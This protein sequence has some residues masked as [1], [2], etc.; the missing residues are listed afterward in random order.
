MSQLIESI[1]Y[2]IGV[3]LLTHAIWMNL[4]DR[5]RG[6]AAAENPN[7]APPGPTPVSQ[8][9]PARVMPRTC[10]LCGSTATHLMVIEIGA[11]N[12][13][14]R[15]SLHTN[16]PVC[17]R[18]LA[19]LYQVKAWGVPIDESRYAESFEPAPVKGGR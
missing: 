3:V 1:C 12:D 2:G 14:T 5:R 7:P 11:A 10:R 8:I 9:K 17:L 4:R 18:H 16:F 19:A 13:V 15:G 6:R